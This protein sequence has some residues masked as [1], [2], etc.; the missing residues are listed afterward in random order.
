MTAAGGPSPVLWMDQDPGRLERDRHEIT[1]FA[2]NLVFVPP[3]A[4][5]QTHGIWVGPIPRWPFDRDE[6]DGLELLVGP[7]AFEIT[8]VYPSAYPM[9]PPLVFP[10]SVTPEPIEHSQAVWHVAP[11]GMLCLLQS[12]GGWLPEASVTELLQKA[13]GWRIE[14]ALMKAGAIDQMTTNGIVSDNSLDALIAVT[15]KA[16]V[17]ISDQA[18]DDE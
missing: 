3:D 6:P 11:S 12:T 9:T 1:S 8:L 13:A 18:L 14:Y 17:S 16:S 2:P 4:T 5:G 10:E 15:A 7:D